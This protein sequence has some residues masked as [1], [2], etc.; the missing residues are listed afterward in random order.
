MRLPPTVSAAASTKMPISEAAPT[1]SPRGGSLL[2]A[3]LMRKPISVAAASPMPLH[4]RADHELD[5]MIDLR[6][7]AHARG[8]FNDEANLRGA[9]LDEDVDLRG[10][11]DPKTEM[12]NSNPGHAYD[13]ELPE[14]DVELN[15]P[16]G[17]W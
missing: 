5:E 15:S 2:A 8:D 1:K 13:D 6:G 10:E 9:G 3:P 14:D 16:P 11:S 17:R 7:G 12:P 4:Y